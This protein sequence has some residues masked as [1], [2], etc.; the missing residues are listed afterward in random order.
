[1]CAIAIPWPHRCQTKR[2]EQFRKPI[3][4]AAAGLRNADVLLSA[5]LR[6]W[7]V[8]ANA[9]AVSAVT[10]VGRHIT[11]LTLGIKVVTLPT[12]AVNAQCDGSFSGTEHH[13][14]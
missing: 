7:V 2:S 11:E 8:A 1:M 5:S 9:A 13:R 10:A 4:G 3:P 12:R 14:G 6:V